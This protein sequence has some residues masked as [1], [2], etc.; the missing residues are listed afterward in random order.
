MLLD[1]SVLNDRVSQRYE[2]RQTLI[3][4]NSRNIPRYV[5]IGLS[6]GFQYVIGIW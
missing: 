3:V 4:L 1:I 6:M 2:M 5:N